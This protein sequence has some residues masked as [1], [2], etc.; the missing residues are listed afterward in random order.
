MS[1]WG[2]GYGVQPSQFECPDMVE[3][4]VDGNPD[5]KKWAL[6]VNVNPGCYFGGEVCLRQ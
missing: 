1:G 4:P 3:L 2:E 5:H 6:I